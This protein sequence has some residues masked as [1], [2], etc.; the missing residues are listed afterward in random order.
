MDFQVLP[1][2]FVALSI[3]LFKCWIFD[4]KCR[5]RHL[6]SDEW[7]RKQYVIYQRDNWQCVCCGGHG[8]KLSVHYKKSRSWGMAQA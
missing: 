6:K 7:Q 5:Q 2:L 3:W 4:L 8:D 1:L